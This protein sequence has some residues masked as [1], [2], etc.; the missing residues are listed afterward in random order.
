MVMLVAA[1]GAR[2]GIWQP[3]AAPNTSE[4]ITA[5]DYQGGDRFW[6]AMSGKIF[7]RSGNGWQKQ[8]DQPGVVFN[9][10][11]FNSTGTIGIAVGDAHELWRY[12]GGQWTKLP[13]L[14]S[15][16]PADAQYCRAPGGATSAPANLPLGL[17]LT[18][19]RW[20]SDDSAVF[21]TT[22]QNG[23]LFR[24][25][26]NGATWTD[27]NRQPDGSC[28]IDDVIK[29]VFELPSNHNYILAEGYSL[30]LSTNG[31]TSTAANRG[32]TYWADRMRVDEANPQ[33]IFAGG[34]QGYSFGFSETGG[35][36]FARATSMNGPDQPSY[37]FDEQGGTV[38]SAGNAGYILTSNDTAHSYIQPA[39]GALLTSDWRAVDLASPTQGAVGGLNGALVV[40]DQLNTIPDII[41]P[42]GTI[43]APDTATTGSA[44]TFSAAVADNSGGSGI[45]PNG[46]TWKNGDTPAGSGPSITLSFPTTGYYTIRLTFTDK[47][48]NVGTATKSISITA[49]APLI[50]NDDP[51]GSIT[52]PAYAVAGQPATFTVNASDSGSGIDE[53]GFRWTRDGSFAG[54]GRSVSVTFPKTGTGELAVTFRDRAANQGDAETAVA[55]APQPAD[56]EKPVPVNTPKPQAKRQGGRIVIPLKGG[57]KL[58]PG[59]AAKLGCA[60]DII[61]TLNKAKTLLSA[62]STKLNQHCRYSKSFSVA[63]TKVGTVKTLRL[64]VRFSGNGW[65]APGKKT[66]TIKVPH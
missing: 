59:V 48:G 52:G 26:D 10:L 40:S 21:V 46:Y 3:V 47:A 58:P 45:D 19:V 54:T 2:A 14:K 55:V 1:P 31:L 63:K 38:L 11:E 62:R 51:T 41:A 12:S 37:D 29:D 36:N 24:S 61:F 42:T 66:Y 49:V 27:I 6:I 65:L 57:Y 43:Q 30:W 60:G 7:K 25:L 44:V 35:A 50:D 8:L 20:V 15:P 39:D 34:A 13:P 16:Y 18:N 17:N 64:T 32:Y 4:I 56:R 33:R 23:R 28:R 22:D 53:T 5:I 9:D